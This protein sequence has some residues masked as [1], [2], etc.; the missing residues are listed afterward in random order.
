MKQVKTLLG[1]TISSLATENMDDQSNRPPTSD[2]S[3]VDKEE[4]ELQSSLM[5]VNTISVCE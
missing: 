1:H 5:E 2:S 3:E 4:N